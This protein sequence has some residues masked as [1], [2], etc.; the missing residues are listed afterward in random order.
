MRRL[1]A[2]GANQNMAAATGVSPLM[3]AARSGAISAMRS[4]LTHKANPNAKENSSGQTALMWAAARGHADVVSALSEGSADVR[5]R[6]ITGKKLV[7][8]GGPEGG[9]DA[10]EVAWAAI[11][12]AHL[13]R[14][15]REHRAD[16]CRPER[17]YRMR[18][19]VAREWRRCQRCRCR[20]Q[21]CVGGRRSQRPWPAT[22]NSCSTKALTRM[23]AGRDT[24]C[25]TP[26]S[27]VAMRAWSGKAWHGERIQMRVTQWAPK[28]DAPTDYYLPHALIGATPYVLAA[29]FASTDMMRDL[30]T[31]GAERAI[32][33]LRNGTTALMA[34][35]SSNHRRQLG[36]RFGER[37]TAE[38]IEQESVG[39][40]NVALELGADVNAADAEGNTA[41]HVATA[42]QFNSIIQLL[43]ANAADVQVKNKSGQTPLTLASRRPRGAP[44]GAQTS[45]T[46]DLFR[47][48]GAKS[49]C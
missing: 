11:R 28:Q 36:Y 26:R 34:A 16:V 41:L 38:A 37:P 44:V 15:R 12:D 31:A 45:G 30:A 18:A 13:G 39:P 17:Q 6:S 40:V 9:S 22:R 46:A 49:N 33:R 14:N 3:L 20:S 48:L 7:D 29:K 5:A 2:A 24:Q 42:A 32:W 19:S 1:L 43:V 21:Q 35:A 10:E 4:L 23:Q 47:K 27:S 8:R 25:S